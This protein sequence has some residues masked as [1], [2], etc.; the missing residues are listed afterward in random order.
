MYQIKLKGKKLEFAVRRPYVPYLADCFLQSYKDPEKFKRFYKVEFFARTCAFEA[1]FYYG[2]EARD[3]GETMFACESEYFGV[4]S[5]PGQKRIPGNTLAA[6]KRIYDYGDELLDFSKQ[7]GKIDFSNYSSKE[8]MSVFKKFTEDY[9][10]FCTALMGFNIQFIVEEKIRN[11]FSTDPKQDEKVA[12]L[13][14]PTKQNISVSEVEALLQLRLK[15]DASEINKWEQVGVT[16]HRILK[17]HVKKYGWINARGAMGA[18]WTEKDIFER[19]LNENDCAV[20]LKEMKASLAL[21]QKKTVEL[22]RGIKADKNIKY[23]VE[24]AKELVYF[25]TYRTDYLNWIFF[26]VRPLFVALAKMRGCEYED[27]IHYLIEEIFANKK[28]SPAEIVRRKA[29]FALMLL[30]PYELMFSSD[31]KKIKLWKDKYTEKIEGEKKE[32]KGATAFK[33]VV[34]GVVRVV[35]N[36]EDMSKFKSGEI[37]VT[38]MTTPNMIQI[39]QKAVAFV[40]DEGGITCHAAIVARELKKPCVIGTK[41]ATQVLKDG[42]MI[43][44]D[45]NHGIIKIIK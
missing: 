1:D 26:N 40:T 6:F 14:F 4:T 20:R 19:A 42:D 16:E 8:L 43:E 7:I 23:L 34:K 36:R 29:G 27:I 41:I 31:P 2:Y 35:K 18:S 13:T 45:A 28:V 39:M 38:S 25:R 11:L 5:L 9:V 22:L 3:F 30:R 12:I 10:T 32:I 37:L 24:V 33:G 17:Q 15:L 21:H 44:I